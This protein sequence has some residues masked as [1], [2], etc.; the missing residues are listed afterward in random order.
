[1]YKRQGQDEPERI[2]DAFVQG[3]DA[4]GRARGGLGIGLTLVRS[5]VELHGGTVEAHSDG[6]GTGCEF[7]VR[8]PLRPAT[9]SGSDD[10]AAGLPALPPRQVLV[11]D[12]NVDAAESLAELLR[13]CG[14]HVRTA[15][16]GAAAI[17][18]ALR[19]RPDIVLVDIAMPDIDGYE[20]GRRLRDAAALDGVTLVALTGFGDEPHRRRS[21]E[22]GFD[23]HLTKPVDVRRLGPLFAA[24]DRSL[25]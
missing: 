18:E 16:S 20:V 10:A 6:P 2:F 3:A 21:E 14:Q 25:A 23:H 4:T 11:V 12:D 7:V 15:H 17:A 1:M 9:Q 8:L 5:L 13:E 19:M 22:A 24:A